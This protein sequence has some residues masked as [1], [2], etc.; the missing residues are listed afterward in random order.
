MEKEESLSIMASHHLLKDKS[1]RHLFFIALIVTL[2]AG[3]SPKKDLALTIGDIEITKSE[4][5]QA[6]R[7]S[8]ETNPQTFLDQFISKKVILRE[9]ERRGLDRDPQFMSDI[10]KY[11]EQGLLKRMLTQK[12]TELASTVS[13]QEVESYYLQHK[14]EFFAGKDLMAVRAE[15]QSFLARDKQ[16]AALNAWVENLRKQTPVKINDVVLEIPRSEVT[17]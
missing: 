16:N 12:N 14:N 6:F 7:D 9:A 3:C 17:K 1:M 5:L 13:D 2:F 8:G 15:I 4:F 10:Q 11:W